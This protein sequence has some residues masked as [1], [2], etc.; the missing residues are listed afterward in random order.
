LGSQRKCC[1]HGPQRRRRAV[2]RSLRSSPGPLPARTAA[3]PPGLSR[4]GPERAQNCY[5]S[6]ALVRRCRLLRGSKRVAA[7]CP[8][9]RSWRA[10]ARDVASLQAASCAGHCPRLGAGATQ[11]RSRQGRSSQDRKEGSSE[12]AHGLLAAA[13][14]AVRCRSRGCRKPPRLRLL[15]VAIPFKW[16]KAQPSQSSISSRQLLAP[17]RGQTRLP[18]PCVW[19]GRSARGDADRFE[20]LQPHSPS[21]PCS[22]AAAGSAPAGGTTAKL[23]LQ[24]RLLWGKRMRCS[25]RLRGVSGRI[26]KAVRSATPGAPG[27]SRQCQRQAG[28]QPEAGDAAAQTGPTQPW[29]QRAINRSPVRSPPGSR[30]GSGESGWLPSGLKAW[31]QQGLTPR[32]G[33]L[34]R[35]CKPVV[36]RRRQ[37]P[38][39]LGLRPRSPRNGGTETV[40]SKSVAAVG[41]R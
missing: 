41:W 23:Q 3:Q 31:G 21:V 2:L 30:P 33:S 17:R 8:V 36:C 11:A 19:C 7:G 20:D 35:K 15:R 25:G 24:L 22:T 32:Q 29:L 27:P 5:R 26:E 6:R 13:P 9:A 28:T 18:Q 16:S 34:C 10:R 4:K 14:V 40:A 37:A 38:G 39:G 12:S 1:G